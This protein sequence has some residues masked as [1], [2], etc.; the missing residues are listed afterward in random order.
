LPEDGPRDRG[1]APGE[2][3]AYHVG[4]G[5]FI[6]VDVD[7]LVD[8]GSRV[9]VD[10]RARRQRLKRS[11]RSDNYERGDRDRNSDPRAPSGVSI[12]THELSSLAD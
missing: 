12:Y 3:T 2:R 9:V 8:T 1:L 10:L 4:I 11:R 5:R 6:P 7:R